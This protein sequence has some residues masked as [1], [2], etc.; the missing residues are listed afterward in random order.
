MLT[1]HVRG[2]NILDLDLVEEH[3]VQPW[4]MDGQMD[5]FCPFRLLSDFALVNL[6]ET[7]CETVS[8][9]VSVKMFP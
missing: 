6:V 5:Q 3:L 4:G 1:T 2:S 9:C 8:C 7:W